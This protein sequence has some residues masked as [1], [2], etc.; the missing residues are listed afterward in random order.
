[1]RNELVVELR[2]ELDGCQ[3]SA[4]DAIRAL[5]GTVEFT[6][7]AGNAVIKA[8]KPVVQRT[9]VTE[10]KVS[11]QVSERRACWNKVRLAL[12]RPGKP[13]D[14]ALIESFHARF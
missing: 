9:L 14:N 6:T 5:G 1:M 3:Q 7:M 2:A 4:K 11:Y 8:L 12:S 10:M 13:T